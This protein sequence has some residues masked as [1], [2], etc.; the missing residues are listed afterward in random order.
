M[1]GFARTAVVVARATTLKFALMFGFAVPFISACMPQEIGYIDSGGI[2]AATAIASDQFVADDGYVL[3]LRRWLPKGEPKA[4]VIA[5]H[6][7]ND[8]SNA[9]AAP[10]AWLADHG[11]AVHAYDQRGFGAG[12]D[13][14]LWAG[15]APLIADL[16]AMIAATRAQSPDQ[17]LY[18]LGESMGGGVILAAWAEAPLDVD[19][20]V[21]A[22]PAVWGRAGM[23]GYMQT[24]LWLTAHTMPWLKL[25]GDGLDI[26]PSDNIDMLR[27]LGA[28]PLVI[29]ETRVDAMWGLVN[30]MDTALNAADDF[31]APALILVGARDEIVP[32]HATFDFLNRRDAGDQTAAQTVAIYE[33]GF[34]MLLRDLEAATVWQDVHTWIDDQAAALPSGADRVSRDIL[35]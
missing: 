7:F 10:G 4:T 20:I 34:H 18:L 6:G 1:A 29:K 33:A 24:S 3:P 31:D 22:A 30:L 17:P 27:G 26:T 12:A 5:L 2:D 8:Y 23:P 21:L 14:G 19:G 15:T 16:R 32:P 13:A 11:I 28:D 9:F 25:T 35:R